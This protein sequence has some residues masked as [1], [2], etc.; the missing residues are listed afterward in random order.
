[1]KF[2]IMIRLCVSREVKKRVIHIPRYHYT[3][4]T[5]WRIQKGFESLNQRVSLGTGT[6]E[7]KK[8]NNCLIQRKPKNARH[9]L[10]IYL[11]YI[12]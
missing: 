6:D 2:L 7:I 9:N 11:K 12:L 1:M 10:Y 3:V 4:N 8:E 5:S